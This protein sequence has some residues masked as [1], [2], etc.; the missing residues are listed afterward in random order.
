MRNTV[1]LAALVLASFAG[2]TPAQT[3]QVTYQGRLDVSGVPANGDFSMRFV[4]YDVATGGSFLSSSSIGSVPV[5]DGLFTQTFTV[6]EEDFVSG[7]TRWLEI[8]VR[9]IGSTDPYTVL[10]PRQRMT[11]TPYAVRSLSERWTD[12]GSGLLL[13]ESADVQR[14]LINRTT[15]ID[16]NEILGVNSTPSSP[17]AAGVMINA[18]S[19]TGRSFLGFATNSVEQSRLEWNSST[20][21]LSLT[22]GGN[23][24]LTVSTAGRVGVMGSPS[25]TFAL[26]VTGGLNATTE[27][28]SPIF[29]Y[30]SSQQRYLSIAPEAFHAR[31][32][33]DNGNFGPSNGAAYLA[34]GTS[35]NIV[36]GVQLPDGAVVN[37]FQVVMLDNTA[38]TDISVTLYRRTFAN[39]GYSQMA[40]VVSSGASATAQTVTDPT[41]A[42][43]TVD[44]ALY[45]Y[46]VGAFSSDWQGSLSSIKAVRIGYTVIQPD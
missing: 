1:L 35:D 40:N 3:S 2:V 25:A 19:T 39:T 8:Q 34:T 21:R 26:N 23:T 5:T 44:N 14:V 27:V 20:A 41:I 7:A 22:A 6:A 42:N 46:S 24:A 36:A 32:T 31:D 10:T 13:N 43:P 38:A 37:E 12:N 29:R 30:P 4:V 9:P 16:A 28:V 18:A 33:T 45:V 17:A 11:A 15:T